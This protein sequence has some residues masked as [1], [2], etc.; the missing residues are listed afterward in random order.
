M[1]GTEIV[2]LNED[3]E[4]KVWYDIPYKQVLKRNDTKNL[5]NRNKTALQNTLMVTS[6]EEW[7]KE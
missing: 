7:Q 3:R 2:I 5:Q 4:R 6:G 1:E